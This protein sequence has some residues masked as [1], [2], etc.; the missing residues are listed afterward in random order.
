M[1]T[2]LIYLGKINWQNKTK[3]ASDKETRDKNFN[4]KYL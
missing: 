2:T 4:N 3:N 1:E